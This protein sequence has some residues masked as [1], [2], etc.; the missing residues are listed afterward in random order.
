MPDSGCLV[1]SP[2]LSEGSTGLRQVFGWRVSSSEE[3]TRGVGRPDLDERLRA[4]ALAYV[5]A[6]SDRNGVHVTRRE[7]ESFEFEGR[8]VR[9]IAPQQGIW[10][11]KGSEA[12]LSIVTAYARRPDMRPYDDR[13]GP[14][15]YPRYK[16]RGTDPDLADNVALRRAMALGKP[17]MW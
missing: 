3:H 5:R 13:L 16:W 4:A 12:A 10:W 7:L 1:V 8:R 15:G 17:L 14:D 2:P 11:I 9:L 6:A